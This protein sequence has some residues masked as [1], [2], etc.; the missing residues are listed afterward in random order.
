[1]ED[2]I[3]AIG[4]EPVVYA[5]RNECCGGYAVME[6]QKP[7]RRRRAPPS[8]ITPRTCRRGHAGDGMP[9][10]PV[11]PDQER[12]GEHACRWYYFTELLAEALGVKD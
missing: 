3:R 6:D 9:P 11:Q 10:V 5:N 12:A 4:A 7:L 8:W 2:F 1:M